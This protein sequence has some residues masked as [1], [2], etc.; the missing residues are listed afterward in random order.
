MIQLTNFNTIILKYNQKI[1]IKNKKYGY[2]ELT[3][4]SDIYQYWTQRYNQP[5]TEV[6]LITLFDGET[7]QTYITPEQNITTEDIQPFEHFSSATLK[8]R[9]NK[10]KKTTMGKQKQK[11]TMSLN[12]KIHIFDYE[13]SFI[14]NPSQTDFST[15]VAGRCKILGIEVMKEEQTQPK[16]KKVSKEKKK[17]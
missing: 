6:T 1:T 7:N 12:K 14:L 17:E 4:P 5:V 16:E 2:K 15:D 9:I 13:V 3:I 8:I 10:M 11:A